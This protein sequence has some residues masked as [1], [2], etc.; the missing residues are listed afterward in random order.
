MLDVYAK[1]SD[2]KPNLQENME[3]AEQAFGKHQI[4]LWEES[5][6][7]KGYNPAKLMTVDW[8]G[9]II[10]G[11]VRY[12]LCKKLNIE[13][14]RIDHH[15]LIRSIQNFINL[16][17]QKWTHDITKNSTEYKTVQAVKEHLEIEFKI[18]M[19]LERPEAIKKVELKK[20]GVEQLEK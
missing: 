11:N 4:K 10:D 19:G 8:K 7:Q 16:Q 15:Y 1:I 6:Q 13:Y 12:H 18:A 20:T 17:T 5:L 2:L 9:C 14:V 3:W